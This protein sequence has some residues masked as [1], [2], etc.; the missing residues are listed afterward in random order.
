MSGFCL[1]CEL[2]N[3]VDCDSY[4]AMPE[5]GCCCGYIQP[6][7]IYFDEDD[8]PVTTQEAGDG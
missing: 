4:A 3:C 2:F 8:A 7:E 6:G 5:Y 1:D